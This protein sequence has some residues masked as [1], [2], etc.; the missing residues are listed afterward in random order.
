MTTHKNNINYGTRISDSTININRVDIDSVDPVLDQRS[1]TLHDLSSTVNGTERIFNLN[2]KP[3]D[4]FLKTF[5]VFIDGVYQQPST[6][7][8][9][10]NRTAVEFISAPANGAKLLISYIEERD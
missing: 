4:N 3:D 9:Y 8:L 10:A 2:P 1:P 5:T 6:Y 7:T